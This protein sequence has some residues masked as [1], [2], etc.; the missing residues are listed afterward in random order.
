MTAESALLREPRSETNHGLRD[1]GG[2][3]RTRHSS[4]CS[5]ISSPIDGRLHD[6][7]ERAPGGARAALTR[8]LSSPVES[9]DRR[10]R[11]QQLM[12]S[13]A[14]KQKP[15]ARGCASVPRYTPL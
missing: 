13:P 14:R 10:P 9:L 5:G 12:P 15:D 1:F 3:W 4:I 7:E 2:R 8:E 6:I 11:H